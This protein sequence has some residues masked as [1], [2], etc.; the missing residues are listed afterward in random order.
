MLNFSDLNKIEVN[1]DISNEVWGYLLNT[2]VKEIR[3]PLRSWL[4]INPLIVNAINVAEV[5]IDYEDE[6]KQTVDAQILVSFLL[7]VLIKVLSF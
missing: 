4:S 2:S 3:A 5:L 1:C 7:F 6:P